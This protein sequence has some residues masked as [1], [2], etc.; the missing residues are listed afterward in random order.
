MPGCQ[1]SR[2]DSISKRAH[3]RSRVVP[4]EILTAESAGFHQGHRQ[5]I[6]QRELGGGRRGGREVVRAGLLF[7]AH[8]QGVQ[9][10]FGDRAVDPSNHGDKGNLP[11]LQQ[12]Q[13]L[14]QLRGGPALGDGD[15]HILLSDHAEVAVQG[16]GGVEECGRRAGAVEGGHGLPGHVGTFPDAREDESPA[17]FSLLENEGNRAVKVLAESLGQA[18]NGLGF[19]AKGAQCGIPSG[20]GSG[21]R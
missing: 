11:G 4:G 16:I 3:S 5:R 7:H 20:A 10:S 15:D 13:E 9:G 21:G 14:D 17:R 19:E 6:A 1:C 2:R 12:G 8:I 18:R